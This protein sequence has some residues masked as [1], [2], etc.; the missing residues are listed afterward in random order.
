MFFRWA[1]RRELVRKPNLDDMA[2]HYGLLQEFIARAEALRNQRNPANEQALREIVARMLRRMPLEG[3]ARQ[4][5]CHAHLEFQEEAEAVAQLGIAIAV[6]PR[7][8]AI[9]PILARLLRG[10]GEHEAANAVLENGWEQRQ[11]VGALVS[12]G[13]AEEREKYFMDPRKR[14]HIEVRGIYGG[15]PAEI[16]ERGK[17]LD[18]YG[19]NA[20]WL[21]SGTLSDEQIALLRDQGAR[22]FAEFNTLHEATYLEAHPEAAPVGADGA[23]CPPPDGWQGI[24]PTHPGY[25]HCRM[26]AFR[27]VLKRYPVDGI[28]LDYHH[29]HASWEQEE[30]NLPDTCFCRRC[31]AQFFESIGGTV[32]DRPTAEVAREV[33]A[34]DQRGRWDDWR[35]GVFTDWVR[36]FHAI[37]DEVRPEALLGTFHCPW[38]ADER[39]GALRSKLAID[40]RAQAEFFDVFSPM[41]YHARFGHDS[42]PAWIGRQIAWLGEHLGVEGK[43]GERPR[44]WPIVQLSDWGPPVPVEQVRTVLKYGTQLP[45]T[46][47]TVFAWGGLAGQW[48]KVEELGTFYRAIR[49]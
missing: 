35:C 13:T 10:R 5:A 26:D 40:L 23:V 12:R 45:A 18:D 39:D 16:L 38:T 48:D 44:I 17:T 28:W 3:I 21:G 1:R 27:E 8:F 24:C 30:P 36:E 25:R 7:N 49:A 19:I 11:R 6:E 33:L 29:S 22:V 47:L 46:G 9:H 15:V 34:P 2:E 43:P 37:R 42:D 32:P 31:L 14:P 4:F 41:P 20:V